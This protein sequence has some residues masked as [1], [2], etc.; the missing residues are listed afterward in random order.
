MA[1]V[2]QPTRSNYLVIPRYEV[3]N[4]QEEAG[5]VEDWV[6]RGRG[7]DIRIVGIIRLVNLS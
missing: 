1:F 6:K 3:H 5:N 4:V 2:E 7:L